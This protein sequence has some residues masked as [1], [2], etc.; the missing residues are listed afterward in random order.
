MALPTSG[1]ITL[2]EIHVEAGGTTTTTATINDADIRALIGKA[3]GVTMSFDEWYGATATVTINIT[4]TANTNNYNI[5]SSKGGTYVAGKTIVNLTINSGVVV[6]STSP[7]TPALQTGSPW[8]SGDVINIINNGTIKGCGGTGGAGGNP[9][10]SSFTDNGDDGGDGGTGFKAEFATTFTNNGS[11][12]GG[13]GG[14]GGGTGAI[15]LANKTLITTANGGGGGGGGAGVNGG[16]GGAGGVGSNATDN[17][18]GAAGNNGTSTAGG[19]GGAGASLNL[20]I[21]GGGGAGGAL[22]LPGTAGGTISNNNGTTPGDGGLAGFYEEGAN[23]INNGNG[24]G[25][26]VGGRT[27]LYTPLAILGVTSWVQASTTSTSSS[28]S[29]TI[30]TGTKSIVFMGGIGTN[31]SRQTRHTT[32]TLGGSA[33][34][35]VI[36]INNSLAQYTFDSII[37]AGNTSLT[38]TQTAVFNYT[39]G[40]AAYG[41]GH[42]I[43]FL[44]KEF[45]S[46]VPSS[47]DSAFGTTN[48]ITLSLTKYGEG[49]QLGAA[50]VRGDFSGSITN[51]PNTAFLSHPG[52]RSSRYGWG[53]TSGAYNQSSALSTAASAINNDYG[54]T[55]CAVTF[56]PAK[57]NN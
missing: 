22:G 46:F 49:L 23:L 26:V 41:S 11:V 24:I 51:M 56:A 27:A 2:D 32:A 20:I 3:A 52:N 40:Q 7:N 5:F 16:T 33:L 12:Y 9:N 35:E 14:G 29:I 18:T 53:I 42:Y 10:Y 28:Q 45:N 25:G 57:F 44:N 34:T 8:T 54:E 30:P 21:A 36:S 19:A 38:G 13:G 50:T 1:T 37:Y 43:I 48:P 4:L 39:A 55:F 15:G 6:G 17:G 31:G 47:S